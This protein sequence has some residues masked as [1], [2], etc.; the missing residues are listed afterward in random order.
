MVMMNKRKLVLVLIMPIFY[1]SA[2]ASVEDTIPA[3]PG[4]RTLPEVKVYHQ[5]PM[6]EIGAQITKFDSM[7]LKENVALSM[8]D[9][10]TFNSSIFV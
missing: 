6:K 3:V 8:A 9:V 4:L 1:T 5:R 10:L 7:A 2:M